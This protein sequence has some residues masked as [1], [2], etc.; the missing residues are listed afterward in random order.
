[1]SYILLIAFIK[2]GSLYGLSF[3]PRRKSKQ[4]II[5]QPPWSIKSL[6]AAQAS[7]LIHF[8]ASLIHWIMVIVL[9]L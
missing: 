4:Q 5:K 6:E 8:K 9:S 2:Y 1:M 3:I 7:T